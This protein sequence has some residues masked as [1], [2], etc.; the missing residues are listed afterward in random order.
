MGQVR[1]AGS[2]L[3]LAGEWVLAMERAW[4]P[5]A[6]VE[7]EEEYLR[8][9]VEFPLLSQYRR[10]IPNTPNKLGWQKLKEPAFF[11]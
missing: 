6:V 3:V 7:S 2:V 4:V 10:R 1:A 11:G 8:L 9:G 5:V